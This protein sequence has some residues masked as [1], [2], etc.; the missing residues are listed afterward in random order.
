MDSSSQVHPAMP[1]SHP[2]TCDS[3]AQHVLTLRQVRGMGFGCSFL[4]SAVS[5][6]RV[7]CGAGGS[8][9]ARDR[10]RELRS[11]WRARTRSEAR[12]RLYLSPYSTDMD[13][14]VQTVAVPDAAVC[15]HSD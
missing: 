14:D 13:A 4:S 15:S 11:W 5:S 9:E 1:D 10:T 12:T 3:D 7:A 8:D 2:A 6:A